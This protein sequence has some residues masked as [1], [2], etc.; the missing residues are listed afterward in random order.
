MKYIGSKRRI[1]KYILPIMLKNR[2][3][4]QYF[5]D[6]MTGGANLIDKIDGNR[7]AADSNEYLIQALKLIRDNPESLPKN[8]QEFTEEMYNQI[9]YDDSNKALK[10]YAGFCF[11][12]GGKWFGG[13]SRTDSNGISKRDYVAESYRNAIKQSPL[14]KD[15]EFVCCDYQD[16]IIP[17]SSIVYYD[18]P[19]LNT[20][21][22]KDKFDH[23]RFYDYCR[24]ISQKHEVYISEYWLPS[25]F[26]ILWEME[27]SSSLDTKKSK[28]GI[29]RLFKYKGN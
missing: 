4:N 7:I 25:D 18:P 5:V 2:K 12:F 13:W 6:A 26:E 8:N 29:E 22:Y 1:A 27:I 23:N 3:P 20:T 11:S 16:L 17:D 28:T 24:I 15:I 19:Y 14:L 9:K 10:G 21:K